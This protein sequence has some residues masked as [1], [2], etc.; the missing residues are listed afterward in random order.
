MRSKLPKKS[1][2]QVEAAVAFLADKASRDEMSQDEFRK[3]ARYVIANSGWT[4]DE[5][6]KQLGLKGQWPKP[7]TDVGTLPNGG[8]GD[9]QP[10]PNPTQSKGIAKM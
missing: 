3:Q 10:S 5:Y 8:K 2:E 7:G 6:K 4:L 1:F 9:A